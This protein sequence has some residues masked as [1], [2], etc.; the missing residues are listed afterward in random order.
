MTTDAPR[1]MPNKAEDIDLMELAGHL[2]AGK[3]WIAGFTAAAL[4]VGAF[5]VLKAT[6]IFQAEG[7][8]QLESKSGAAAL[9]EG[10]QELLGGASTAKSPGESEMVIMTSRMVM[11]EVA[12]QLN[13]QIEAHPRPWPLVGMLPV[14]IGVP[15]FWFGAFAAYQRGNEAISVSELSLPKEWQGKDLVLTITAPGEFRLDL[16]D[17]STLEGPMRR[18]VAKADPAVSIL[19]DNLQGPVGREFLISNQSLASEVQQLQAN[20]SVAEFP[21]G[22]SILRV[23]FTDP[24]PRKAEQ[25]LDAIAQAYVSQ[26]ISRSAAE[27]RNSLGFI[28]NQ[29]PKAEEAVVLAQDALNVYQQAQNSVDVDYETKSLLDR[30]TQ[31]ETELN[32]LSLKE[33][34][35][36]DRYTIQ[37]PVYQALLQNRATLEAQLADL[38][39]STATLP[40]TQKEIFNLSRNLEVAQQVYVQLLNRQ[41]ELRVV[42]ASTVGSVRVIDTAYSNGIKVAPRGSKIMMLHLLVGLVLGAGFVLG[43]RML[44]RGI[45]GAQEIEKLGLPVFATVNFSPAAANH[46]ARKGTLPIM[47]LTNPDDL[48]IEALR[49]LRTSLHF[50]MLDAETNTIL[51]TS[52]AP[53]AGKTFTSVNFAVVAAQAGQRVCVIDADLRKGYLRRYFGKDKTT[54]GL[55]EYLAQEK[56]L[57]EVMFEGPV[58]GLWVIA[59]GRF[60]PNPSELLMRAEFSQLLQELSGMFDLVIIDSPPALAVTDP[61]VIGRFTGARILV[62]RHMETMA[63][64]VEAV[65]RAFESAG[66]K[67]TGAILNGYKVEEGARYG[68]NSH[69]YNYR[70]DYKSDRT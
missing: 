7:L 56:T 23:T 47:A 59:S 63:G 13:L 33:E 38:R 22:S 28:D 27:A 62:A 4:A 51:I 61:V 69:Y 36:K 15:D 10:M 2:W 12:Q 41:Q 48:V 68:G 57:E 24:S 8:L 9:P 5:T 19:V 16:P 46:R 3:L 60:P 34:E 18:R 44:S 35:L 6:P 30:A 21:R 11:S 50:G 20:F 53:G 66:S 42:Q 43:R 29:L 65:K 1:P 37:H 54:P 45:R 67:I 26:N 64:E 49:S 40:E 55:S 32:A 14:R 31:L 58:E 25:I 39:E 52:A 17:G 70:Y